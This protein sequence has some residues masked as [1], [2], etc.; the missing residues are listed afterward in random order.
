MKDLL[1]KILLLS[2]LSGII[3]SF[4]NVFASDVKD[5]K[6]TIY[7]EAAK[8]ELDPYLVFAII[9]TESSFRPGAIGSAGEIGL[10]Q[11]RPEFHD[12]DENSI[13]SQILTALDYLQYIHS[14][15]SGRYGQAWF[16]CY[17]TGPNRSNVI[18]NP[19]EFIYYKKVMS[20]YK[21]NQI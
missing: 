18:T 17:N 3:I 21:R 10:F 16:I 8:R 12:F 7:I 9:E 20:F 2:I 15:C 1:L 19:T 6:T 11:L 14:R 4:N 13:K 5:I